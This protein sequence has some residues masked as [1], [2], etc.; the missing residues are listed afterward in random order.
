MKITVLGA[1][2]GCGKQLVELGARRGHT[3]TAVAR[4]SSKVEPPVGVKVDRGELTS[5]EFLRGVVRGQH[6]VLSG[7]GLRLGGLGPWNKAEDPTFLSRSTTALI[8][9]MKAEGTKRVLVVSAGG[10]GDSNAMVPGFFRMM[11]KVTAL[12]TAYAQ[13]DEMERQLL[14]SGLDVCVARPTGLTDG[15]LTGK[16]VIAKGFKGR[17]TIS[18]ADVAQW[19]LEQLEK[20]AFDER[21]PMITVTGAA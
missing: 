17:A 6:A 1:S 18:R 7:L 4:S 12:K 9:A 10:V 19:M 8:E 16:A 21:T 5:V 20:P 13:L 2:G 3:V 14:A 11:I 15:P